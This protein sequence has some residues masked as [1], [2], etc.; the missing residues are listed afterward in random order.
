MSILGFGVR[1]EYRRA[2]SS[3]VRGGVEA[4]KIRSFRPLLKPEA[5]VDGETR[6]VL[7]VGI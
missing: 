2:S 4:G 6:G 7:G 1:A 5:G 3:F